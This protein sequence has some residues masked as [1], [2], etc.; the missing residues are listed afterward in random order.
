MA[1]ALRALADV[2]EPAAGLQAVGIANTVSRYKETRHLREHL[3]PFDKRVERSMEAEQLAL[4]ALRDAPACKQ[5][6]TFGSPPRV[7]G[8][9]PAGR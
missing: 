7:P 8:L 4:S 2:T 5:R 6:L 3:T 1:A 9:L